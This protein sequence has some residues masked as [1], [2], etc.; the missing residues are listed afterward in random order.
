MR[1]TIELF[2]TTVDAVGMDTQMTYWAIQF[3]IFLSVFTLFVFLPWFVLTLIEARNGSLTRSGLTITCIF[4]VAILL[5]WT[6]LALTTGSAYTENPWGRLTL[7][8]APG[9]TNTPTLGITNILSDSDTPAGP[10]APNIAAVVHDQFQ[11][12][13]AQQDELKTLE[14]EKQCQILRDENYFSDPTEESILC[15]GYALSP[16]IT[17]GWEIKPFIVAEDGFM[18]PNALMDEERILPNSSFSVNPHALEVTARLRIQPAYQPYSS[19]R[20][21][22]L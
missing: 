1:P 15:G 5:P 22:S 17:F 18:P 11:D 14:L 4:T 12:E 10:N 9:M 20:T 6:Y 19:E 7:T 21:A 3:Y 2:T 8:P 13:L 16:V